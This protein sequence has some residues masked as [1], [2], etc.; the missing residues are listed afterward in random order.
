MVLAL[1]CCQV[2]HP[3]ELYLY[4]H[5][6]AFVSQAEIACQGCFPS[7][8]QKSHP[9]L[10]P[11]AGFP[12]WSHTTFHHPQAFKEKKKYLEYWKK[13]LLWSA[14]V[15]G[16]RSVRALPPCQQQDFGE[17]VAVGK[18]QSWC[19]ASPSHMVCV[20]VGNKLLDL[21]Q[22][23][24]DAALCVPAPGEVGSCPGCGWML[25]PG[26]FLC[27]G[28]FSRSFGASQGGKR[29]L[30]GFLFPQDEPGRPGSFRVGH[31]SLLRD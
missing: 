13:G 31:C 27:Q 29:S 1:V 23:F 26:G 19:N 15:A 24:G 28:R 2:F 12:A 8:Q 10:H 5:R 25:F 30:L 11:H 4:L 6:S 9:S 17:G 3:S 7:S 22:A 20:L 21:F 14:K 18:R 16:G